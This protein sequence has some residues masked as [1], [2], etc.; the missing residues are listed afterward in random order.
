MFF[1]KS[2]HTPHL[3]ILTPLESVQS[4][5]PLMTYIH[6]VIVLD[7]QCSMVSI[8]FS[9]QNKY[10]VKIMCNGTVTFGLYVQYQSLLPFSVLNWHVFVS[11]RLLDPYIYLCCIEFK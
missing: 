6:Q 4:Q 9:R 5:N 11:L 1:S 3:E 7:K 10:C 2:S 8:P